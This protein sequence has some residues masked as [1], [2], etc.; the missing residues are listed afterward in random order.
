MGSVSNNDKFDPTFTSLHTIPT[1]HT[2]TESMFHSPMSL[3]MT[4]GHVAAE[5][6]AQADKTCH[7]AGYLQAYPTQG[8]L[9]GSVTTSN[10]SD[11]D[12]DVPEMKEASQSDKRR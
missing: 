3:G 7:D 10:D 1:G 8:P 5:Q 12:I 9:S 6:E 2:N 4:P 11:I